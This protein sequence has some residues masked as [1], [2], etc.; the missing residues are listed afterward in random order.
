MVATMISFHFNENEKKKNNTAILS[1]EIHVTVIQFPQIVYTIPTEK[2]S[3]FLIRP[4]QL[5][6]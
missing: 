5:D 6:N 2:L 4:I 3:L 1:N